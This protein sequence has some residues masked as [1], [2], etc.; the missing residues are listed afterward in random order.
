M[1]LVAIFFVL[2]LSFKISQ[3]KNQIVLHQLIRNITI[4]R[5]I[6]SQRHLAEV[7]PHEQNMSLSDETSKSVK[8]DKGFHLTENKRYFPLEIRQI[9]TTQ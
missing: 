1:L 7:L 9:V 4:E 5:L 2:F 6:D 3:Y 8:K